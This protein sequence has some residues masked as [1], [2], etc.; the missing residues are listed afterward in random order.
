MKIVILGGA[1][2][3]DEEMAF[4]VD[5]K[6]I[7]TVIIDGGLECPESVMDFMSEFHLKTTDAGI[8]EMADLD[9]KPDV[10]TTNGRL[11]FESDEEYDAFI[12]ANPNHVEDPDG[13]LYFPFPEVLT[14][15]EL[16]KY[17]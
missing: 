4:Y 6:L 15:E 16:K 3:H 11:C 13:D 9:R 17:L 5:G 12:A 8:T 2:E 1:G 14:D 10:V 7:K